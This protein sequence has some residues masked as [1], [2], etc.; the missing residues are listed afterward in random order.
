MS[1]NRAR[2]SILSELLS[3]PTINQKDW[4][5]GASLD[6]EVKTGDLVSLC[7]APSTQWYLS[8]FIES[9]IKNGFTEYLLESIEDGELCWWT[10]VGLNVYDRERVDDRPSWKWNDK[11]F[12]FNDRWM[13]VCK[14]NGAYIVLPVTPKFNEDDSVELNVRVRFGFSDYTNPVTFP[15]WKKLTMKMMDKYY[16]TC[17][18]EFNIEKTQSKVTK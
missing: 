4:N 13:K 7:S 17:V 5:K 3:F 15:N 2:I 10:N 11:Q 12:A 8:W 16:T 14:R 9:R 18:K 6:P 1:K